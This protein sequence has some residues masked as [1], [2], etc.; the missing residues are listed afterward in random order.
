[1]SFF[2]FVYALA[3]FFGFSFAVR[4]PL[5]LPLVCSH[6]RRGSAF[7]KIF[8]PTYLQGCAFAQPLGRAQFRDSKRGDFEEAQSCDCA[9]MHPP[10]G[11]PSFILTKLM[12][13]SVPLSLPSSPTVLFFT[14]LAPVSFKISAH[15][16]P[17]GLPQVRQNIWICLPGVKYKTRF[18]RGPFLV[19][20]CFAAPAL[21]CFVLAGA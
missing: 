20:R 4:F 6:M 5:A 16:I 18:L 8:V 7:I 14:R 10:L 21:R 9:I 15:W 3:L 2:S 13:V 19:P 11:R 17:A 12:Q 1:L